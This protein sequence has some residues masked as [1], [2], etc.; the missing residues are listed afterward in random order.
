MVSEAFYEKYAEGNHWDDHSTIYAESFA[1]FLKARNFTGTIIDLGCGNG[2]DV[3][4]FTKAG[5]HAIG[6]DN[7]SRVITQAK[8]KYP[9]CEFILQDIEHLAFP[10]ESVG[11]FYIINTLHYVDAK[12]VFNQISTRLKK[13]GYMHVHFDEK[14]MDKHGKVDHEMNPEE[15]KVLITGFRVLSE[16]HFQRLDRKPIEHRHFIREMTLQKL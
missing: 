4:V 10:R 16:R 1:S 11:A 9:S 6:L 13:G 7:Q 15:I 3:N 8:E 5:F 12:T 14:I 2:R